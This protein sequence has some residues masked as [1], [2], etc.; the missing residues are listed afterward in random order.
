MTYLSPGTGYDYAE[1]DVIV[2]GAG[3]AG[4]SAA[5]AAAHRGARVAVLDRAPA[6]GGS[7]LMSSGYVWAIASA[8]ELLAEDSGEFQRHGQVIVEGY[9]EIQRWLETLSPS[10]G[11]ETPVLAGRGRKFDLGLMFLAM[12][13]DIQRRNGVILPGTRIRDAD[14]TREGTYH[15]EIDREGAD[16]KHLSSAALV[17]ATGG[18]QADPEVRRRLAGG[19]GTPVLRGNPYSDG[20]GVALACSLGASAN[21]SNLG[22]YGHLFAVGVSPV[23]PI[24]FTSFALYHSEHSILLDRAGRRFTDESRGDHNNAMAVAG[25]GGSALLI[26]S[27]K[28]QEQAATTAFVTASRRMNRFEISK[29]RGG[30]VARAADREEI[31]SILPDLG[32]QDCLGTLSDVVSPLLREG[33]VYLAEVSPAVTFTFGGI[34]VDGDGVAQDAS[35]NAIAGLYAAG[36]DMGDIYHRGYGGGLSAAAITGRRAGHAA[37]GVARRKAARPG[38]AN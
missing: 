23:A 9:A 27:Q 29:D 33:D 31:R 32:Y 20:A 7:A 12:A 35:G 28:V 4:M 26:W 16:T 5:T 8:D 21:L 30:R 6:I 25:H 2:V 10:L 11:D 24:D 18:R 1:F 13:R 17:L 37:A 36:A 14:R 34:S 22:F 19:A 3:M 15:L 38:G